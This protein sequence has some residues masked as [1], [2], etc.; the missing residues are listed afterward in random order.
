MRINELKRYWWNNGRDLSRQTGFPNRFVLS[1]RTPRDLL[2]G[3]SP[4]LYKASPNR[5]FLLRGF[6]PNLDT[7]KDGKG[8]GAEMDPNSGLNGS[9]L[10]ADGSTSVV[11]DGYD[12]M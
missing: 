9:S 5:I 7:E 11:A 6:S 4:S 1:Q 8:K 12:T 3:C 10:V 2:A